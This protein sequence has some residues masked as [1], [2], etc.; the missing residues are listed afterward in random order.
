VPDPAAI[1]YGL[2]GLAVA[3][4]IARRMIVG[5]K[6]PVTRFGLEKDWL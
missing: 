3:Y 4:K 1:V 5:E 2:L 6:P